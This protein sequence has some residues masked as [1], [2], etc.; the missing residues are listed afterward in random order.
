MSTIMTKEEFNKKY[1]EGCGSQRCPGV[2]CEDMSWA[3]GC[4]NYRQF[5]LGEEESKEDKFYREVVMNSFNKHKTTNEQILE[6]MEKAAAESCE[7][8]HNPGIFVISKDDLD[9]LTEKSESMTKELKSLQDKIRK[10]VKMTDD[11]YD[12][13]PKNPDDNM[14]K[15]G[16]IYLAQEIKANVY[17]HGRDVL[18]IESVIEDIDKALDTFGISMK[19]TN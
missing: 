4:S 7:A 11:E 9:K 10:K 18:S 1:C 6:T 13:T 14:K 3:E 15:W 5:V 17:N 8:T 2:F 16:M 19:E 12:F